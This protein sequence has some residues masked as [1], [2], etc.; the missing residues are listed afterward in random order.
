MPECPKCGKPM[1]LRTVQ[2]EGPHYG[3]RFWGCTEYPRCRGVREYL[4]TE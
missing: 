4:V 2:R 1:V 3:K